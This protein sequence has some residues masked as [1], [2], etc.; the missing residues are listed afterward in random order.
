M[1]GRLKTKG[2]RGQ[3]GIDVSLPEA[4]RFRMALQSMA[5]GKDMLAIKV[6]A[7]ANEVPFVKSIVASGRRHL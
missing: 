3:D 5:D 2:R 6:D 7:E 4:T 1:S